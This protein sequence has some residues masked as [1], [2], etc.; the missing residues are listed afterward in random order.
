MTATHRDQMIDDDKR[1]AAVVAHL[2]AEGGKVPEPAR[3]LALDLARLP[4]PAGQWLVLVGW[5]LT[6]YCRH[7]GERLSRYLELDDAAEILHPL[8][9][10]TQDDLATHAMWLALMGRM[11]LE[12]PDQWAKHRPVTGGVK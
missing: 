3:G 10:L 6:L 2:E 11:M 9:K 4:F 5:L 1:L 12:P 8:F 7:E